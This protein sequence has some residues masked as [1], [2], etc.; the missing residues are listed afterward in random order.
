VVRRFLL[1]ILALVMAGTTVDLMLL[2]RHEDAWQLVP[3]VLNACG[4]LSLAACWWGGGPRSVVLLRVVMALFIG[5][6]A[7]GMTLHYLGSLEF[8]KELDATQSGWPL[9][10]KIITAKAPPMLA[11]AVMSQM[12][13]LGLLYT[14]Q[15]PALRRHDGIPPLNSSGVSA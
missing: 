9:F 5:A 10:V 8:Q 2:D 1:L 6:G 12:G 15:H 4:L 11:P 7:L 3:L 13:L 14:Y